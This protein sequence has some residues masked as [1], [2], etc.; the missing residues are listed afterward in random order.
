[1][2]RVSRRLAIFT[3]VLGTGLA[4]FGFALTVTLPDL[5]PKP[6][7]VIELNPSLTGKP[8]HCL[9]CHNGIE[10]ISA[11]HPVDKFG[12]VSCH[13]GNGMATDSLNAHQNIVANPG[14][15]QVAAQYCGGCHP[16]QVALVPHGIMATYAGAISLV[17]RSFGLQPDGIAHFATMT[18]DHL[19]QFRASQNDPLPVQQF[20]ER[21]L[22]CHLN[23]ESIKAPYFYRSSGCSACHVLYN[24][25]GLYQGADPTIPKNQPGH[26]ALHEITKAIPFTQCDHC[27]NRGTYD[28]KTMTFLPRNDMPAP[29]GLSA[30]ALRLHDYYQPISQF[31][32]CEW[33]LDCVD[34]HTP[35]EVMGDGVLHDNKLQAQYIQCST[36]HGTTSS[37]PQQIVITPTAVPNALYSSATQTSQTVLMTQRGEVRPNITFENGKWYLVSKVSGTR[38][39]MPIVAGSKCQQKPDEQAS[40]YCHQCHTYD[41]NNHNP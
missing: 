8:E 2:I 10:T 24:A 18:I 30:D 20:A 28:L 37:P 3:L 5:L 7:K 22:T 27:H 12:C 15:L 39:E 14:S 21:C 31:T 11:S 16:A 41:L 29:A 36:C 17:R 25:E 34:C 19:V 40:Q 32:K 38:Y 23:T 35:L 9:T 13:G 6:L 1:M 4:V 33:K 26:A